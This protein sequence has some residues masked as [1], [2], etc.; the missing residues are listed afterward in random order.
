MKNF[1]SV[2]DTG[3]GCPESPS[4]GIFQHSLDGIL[5]PGI[6]G[7]LDLMTHCGPS[8]LTQSRINSAVNGAPKIMTKKKIFILTEKS[9]PKL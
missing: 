7:R 2:G 1:Y 8:N 4:L 3:T 9:T 6:A 5:C